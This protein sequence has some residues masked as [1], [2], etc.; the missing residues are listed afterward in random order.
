M[1][2]DDASGLHESLRHGAERR[3]IGQRE[4]CETKLRSRI[5]WRAEVLKNTTCL[6]R[7]R[8]HSAFKTRNYFPATSKLVLT[9]AGVSND[10]LVAKPYSERVTVGV[11]SQ[12]Q[13]HPEHL[14][15]YS[16]L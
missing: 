10:E 11:V 15:Q 13:H 14:T 12:L 1:R 6:H 7:Y 4:K 9:A 3:Q 2:G 8:Q 5:R 16:Q